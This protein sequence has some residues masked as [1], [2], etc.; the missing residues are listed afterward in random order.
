MTEITKM[1]VLSTGH[2]TD[3]A[4][5]EFF[6]SNRGPWYE[7]DPFGWFVNVETLNND[8]EQDLPLS[9]EDCLEYA[10]NLDCNWVMFDRD[11]PLVEELTQY[12]W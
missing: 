8:C 5:N 6:Q 3:T 12:D 2:L 1:L 10:I 11:G 7:K 4:C 9:I